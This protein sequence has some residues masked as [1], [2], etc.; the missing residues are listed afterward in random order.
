MRVDQEHSFL[1]D[2]LWH[3]AMAKVKQLPDGVLYHGRHWIRL[4]C[5]SLHHDKVWTQDQRDH[6]GQVLARRREGQS[7][8]SLT[9]DDR[10]SH[11]YG[12]RYDRYI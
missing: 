11:S 1:C 9:L 2:Q 10:P 3:H 6:C 8:G 12:I 5:K 7:T 4:E